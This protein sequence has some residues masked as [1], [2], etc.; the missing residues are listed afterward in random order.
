VLIVDPTEATASAASAG[1]VVSSQSINSNSN[2]N[3]SPI[4][5]VKLTG[6]HMLQRLF[7]GM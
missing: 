5:L 1:A 7:K 3:N 4:I 6:S 2:S